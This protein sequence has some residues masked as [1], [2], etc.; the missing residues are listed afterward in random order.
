M[1]FESGVRNRLADGRIK[2]V[3]GGL[4]ELCRSSQAVGVCMFVL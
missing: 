2:S 4:C 1:N 3:H